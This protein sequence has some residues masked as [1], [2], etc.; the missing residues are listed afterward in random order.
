RNYCARR[1]TAG[2]IDDVGEIAGAQAV[3]V[4]SPRADALRCALTTGYRIASTIVAA[5]TPS[6][7]AASPQR[8][9]FTC[10]ASAASSEKRPAPANATASDPAASTN[11]N[12]IP[13]S[14]LKNPLRKCTTK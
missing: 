11:G 7:N 4:R 12:S 5:A 6:T 3:W 13:P 1:D 10:H 9:P 2:A 14:W 8:Q